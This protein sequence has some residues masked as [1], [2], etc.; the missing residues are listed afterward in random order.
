MKRI[1]LCALLFI[2][3]CSSFK[4]KQER[5][6]DLVNKYLDSALNSPNNYQSRAFSSVTPIFSTYA[7][8]DL[9]GIKL[10]KLEF[11]YMDSVLYYIN[12]SDNYKSH[13][14]NHKTSQKI[15]NYY[16]LKVDSIKNVLELKSKNY[17]GK[18][19]LYKITHT[20]KSKKSDGDWV[21]RATT[22]TLDTGITK[23]VG[24]F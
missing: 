8:S 10:R 13:F 15:S 14:H 17:N 7:S 18:L 19:L 9:Q 3:A 22:F 24:I 2:S 23:V 16:R 4:S 5:A 12:S 20:Y 21:L 6:Q 11:E 1:L